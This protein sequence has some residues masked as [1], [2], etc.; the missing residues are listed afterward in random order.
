MRKL[1]II[2]FALFLTL[3][4]F[5]QPDTAQVIEQLELVKRLFRRGNVDSATQVLND[6][7]KKSEEIDYANGKA[8]VYRYMG[9]IHYRK[10]E[11]S[12]A[13]D[14]WT[15]AADLY[16]E[17]NN[18]G[19]YA[20][21]LNNIALVY[22]KQ[23]NYQ[24][25]LTIL[26]KVADV[27]EKNKDYYSLATVQMN[28][29]NIYKAKGDLGRSLQTLIDA[30]EKLES[31][32]QTDE[33]LRLRADIYNSMAN[34]YR[35]QRDYDNAKKKYEQALDIYKQIDNKD[36]IA[37]VNLNLGVLEY[38]N[39]RYNEALK[40]YKE[41]LK[42][43]TSAVNEPMLALSNYNIGDVYI[44]LEDYQKA[45]EYI[46]KSLKLYEK[47][48]DKRGIASCYNALGEYYYHFNMLDSARNV[49]E[50]ALSY[51]KKIGDLKI[52]E[53]AS[54]ELSSVYAASGDYQKAFE[55]HLLYK[56]MYDS[57]FNKENERK[58]TQL[59]LQYEFERE[60]RESQLK[61][62]AKL[63]QQRILLYSAALVAF[64][65]LL[66]LFV[67]IKLYRTKK[68]A[69]EEL[70]QK[71]IEI[72]KQKQEIEDSI[73]YA[74]RI[75][76]AVMP[77]TDILS[78]FFKDYFLLYKPK[79]IVSGDFFWAAKRENKLVIAVADCTGHGVPGAFMSMLGITFLR[80]IV[81]QID[82]IK[83]DK[84]L[85]QLR[86][87]VINALNQTSDKNVNDGMDISLLVVDI[88]TANAQYSGA[89]NPLYVIRDSNA[90][91]L[92]DQARVF[93]NEEAPGRVLYELKGTRLPIGNYFK[94]RDFKVYN[95]AILDGDVI[96][97]F[98]DGYSDQFNDNNVKFT[99]KRFKK[100]LL[101]IS[102]LSMEEQKQEIDKMHIKWRGEHDQIDDII[103]LGLKA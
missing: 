51:G 3:P 60:K 59:S 87:Q 10:G 36:G 47:L 69:N 76:T 34:I 65:L 83:S 31:S 11:I 45:H 63:R 61:F 4:S 17:Q 46:L 23:G 80:E 44:K 75:Q 6:A 12:K 35:W 26:H 82:E 81:L 68:Q 20:K 38:D 13:V 99:P 22:K 1:F 15:K 92:S 73:R 70:E 67:A 14:Y 54:K 84:I 49:L 29:S 98:S 78:V 7:L 55:N 71:N 57:I 41:A 97:M 24:N 37:T 58:L 62:E 85:S 79:Q 16:L 25:A 88:E 21:M 18:I 66:F 5:A 102:H 30:L 27:F 28:I 42:Q 100:L 86:E 72:T 53:E 39:H 96:Y 77:P 19:D 93:V 2:I 95:F 94:T 52:I 90:P 101:E 40:Y 50:Q 91:A 103:V 43:A 89:Y 8:M 9:L 64:F 32:E 56:Q 33:N 48:G 74:K